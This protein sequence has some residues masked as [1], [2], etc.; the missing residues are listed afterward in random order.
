M[1]QTALNEDNRISKKASFLVCVILASVGGF[2]EAFT[3]LLKGGVFCNAQTGN[4][5]LLAI[6]FIN[7]QYGQA[8]YYILPILAYMVGISC[9]IYIPKWLSKL[10]ILHWETI[11]VGCEI[12]I[13]FVLAFL[14]NTFPNGI[15]NVPISFICA[16]Q[17]NTFRKSNGIPLATT[18][19]TN[20]L[21]QAVIHFCTG[22]EQKNQQSKIKSLYYVSVILFFVIGAAIGTFLI[23]I[24]KEKAILF[25]CFILLPVLVILL[26]SD[27]KNK[28]NKERRNFICQ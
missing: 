26:L 16:M 14:P 10:S 23:H 11:F 3:Y 6:F 2:L 21:R 5:A 13:L 19:C 8:V 18:F 20:N 22:I 27:I 7:K 24:L 17:Y 15:T 9:T 1:E 12:L 25:C 4:F 28:D